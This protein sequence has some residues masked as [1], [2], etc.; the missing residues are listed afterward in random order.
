VLEKVLPD[1]NLSVL[2]QEALELNLILQKVIST[3][4]NGK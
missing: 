1:E 2:Q 4:K 3:M